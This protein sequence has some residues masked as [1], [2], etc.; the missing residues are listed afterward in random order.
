[1]R[2]LALAGALV[3]AA[4]CRTKLEQVEPKLVVSP[5]ALDFGP[6][7]VLNSKILTVT[8]TDEGGADLSVSQ[9]SIQ[10]D[11]GVFSLEGT[12][13]TSVGSGGG[14]ALLTVAFTPPS[15]QAFSG[16][17]SIASDDP[18]IPTASVSLTGVGSTRGALTV[19]PNPLDFGQ[20]GEGIT[21]L[22][23]LT[24]SSVGTAPLLINSIAFGPGSDSAFQFASSTKTPVTLPDAPPGD[25]VQISLRFSPT[26][27][28]PATARGSV[29][30]QSTD[31]SQPSLAIPIQGE[32]I[33]API[34]EIA[35]AG[36]V[37]V[38]S[39][40]TLDGSA[41][42]DPG[43]NT[44]LTYAW[45]LTQKPIGSSAAL[46]DPT[47]V[48][49]TL[50]VDQPG[51]YDFQ[52]GVTNSLGISS[53][54]PAF[55]SLTA[56]PAEDLYVEMIWDNLP[57]DMDIHFLAPGGQLNSPAT[58]CNGNNQTPTGFSAVCSDDHLTGPGPEWAKDAS[59]SAGTYTVDVVYY[60]SHGVANPACNV[61]VRIYVYG[62][63]A[64]QIT[65]SLSTPGEVW[66]VAAIAWP[67]ATITPLGQIQGG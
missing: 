29:V 30:I 52:L 33:L 9:V 55:A 42:Y 56:R 22:A 1:M 5:S 64:A 65:Q 31:P 12:A 44:P 51:T 47:V 27:S 63:V 16:T 58:D 39:Q 67:S 26:A 17:L 13:P 15:E 60:S 36:T 50:V 23:E 21:Q 46:S 41:S 8:L 10:S 59:P 49:P 66:S 11:G 61:T 48:A 3:L 6:V 43:K 57:V 35:D 32:T 38:G 18:T 62:V 20:V 2:W 4:G 37:A 25:S 53:I 28:T 24:L 45:A 34:A 14:K 19:T 40:V 7:P 54:T